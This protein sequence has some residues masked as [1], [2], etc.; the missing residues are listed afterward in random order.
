VSAKNLGYGDR[1]H[2]NVLNRGGKPNTQL[3]LTT[4]ASA[5]RKLGLLTKHNN[6][7]HNNTKTL[8][9]LTQKSD[10]VETC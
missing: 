3:T 1:E 2:N 5:P 9:K 8:P 6:T 7:R 10:T 4:H